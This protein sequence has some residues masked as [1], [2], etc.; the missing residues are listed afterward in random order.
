M[1]LDAVALSTQHVAVKYAHVT[2]YM[3]NAMSNG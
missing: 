1:M 2:L 3:F